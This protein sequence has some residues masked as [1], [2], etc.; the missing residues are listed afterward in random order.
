MTKSLAS[1]ADAE[2]SQRI[3]ENVQDKVDNIREDSEEFQ[4]RLRKKLDSRGKNEKVRH[5]KLELGNVKLSKIKFEE[6]GSGSLFYFDSVSGL[7]IRAC[8]CK[9]LLSSLR[10]V[11]TG[12]DYNRRSSESVS[13]Y[14]LTFNY[15]TNIIKIAKIIVSLDKFRLNIFKYIQE[16]STKTDNLFYTWNNFS[17][18][19]SL[20]SL[21][22]DFLMLVCKFKRKN[23]WIICI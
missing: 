4:Q 5:F 23:F 16:L 2:N 10:I 8:V 14:W 20:N 12:T 9:I 7:K 17:F 15:I 22:S 6:I 21:K 1:L 19:E 18:Q 11:D 3:I 13:L